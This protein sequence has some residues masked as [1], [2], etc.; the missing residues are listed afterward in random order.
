MI[1][2]CILLFNKYIKLIFKKKK[3]IFIIFKNF[4]ILANI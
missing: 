3:I 4:K 1:Q 2:K